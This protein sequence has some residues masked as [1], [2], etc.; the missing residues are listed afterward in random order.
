MATFVTTT[1]D[2][3]RAQKREGGT[4][5]SERPLIHRSHRRFNQC[6]NG[7]SVPRPTG[8]DADP[9]GASDEFYLQPELFRR[10][11]LPRRL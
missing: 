8:L 9:C 6:F 3:R 7:V 11:R 10:R 4:R 5:I 2:E 1:A